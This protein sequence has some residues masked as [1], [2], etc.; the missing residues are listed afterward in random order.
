MTTTAP[1]RVGSQALAFAQAAGE[2]GLR[3]FGMVLWAAAISSVIDARLRE[4]LGGY[5]YPSWLR[6]GPAGSVAA[7]TLGAGSRPS[8]AGTLTGC[9]AGT[10]RWGR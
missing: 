3:L 9:R 1:D 2:V 4:L 7:A 10:G 5:R 6:S 8:V